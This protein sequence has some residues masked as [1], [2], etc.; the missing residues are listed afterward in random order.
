MGAT[1]RQGRKSTEDELGEYK[2][3][4]IQ[5]QFVFYIPSQVPRFYLHMDL[6]IWCFLAL[7][8]FLSN[9]GSIP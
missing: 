2:P 9:E 7:A 4:Q 3:W 8:S 1:C 5:K 6:S